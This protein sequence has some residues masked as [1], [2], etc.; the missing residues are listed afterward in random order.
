MPHHNGKENR[1]SELQFN[2]VNIVSNNPDTE[3]WL[4][5]FFGERCVALVND[6]HLADEIRKEIPEKTPPHSGKESPP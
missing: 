1:M 5:L 3:G 4:N 2:Y 6:K